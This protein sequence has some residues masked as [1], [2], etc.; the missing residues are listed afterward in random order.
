MN[1]R[2]VVD[3]G[4]TRIA[5]G[6]FVDDKIV[7]LSHHLLSNTEKA[8]EDIST[9]AQ[10]MK[11]DE[12]A[13]CSVVPSVSRALV[14]ELGKRKQSVYEINE[15]SQKVIS[16]TYDS[17][18]ADRIANVAGAYQKY[19]S[20]AANKQAAIVIDC[21][22]ATTLSAVSSSGK[23]M[24][25]LI[26]LGLGNTFRALH[27]ATE[28]LPEIEAATAGKPPLALASDTSNA[29]TSGCI[30]AQVGIIE[31]WLKIAKKE[32]GS[33]TTVIATGGYISII[34]PLTDAF[35]YVD[36]ELTLYGINFIAQAAK[37]RAD[38]V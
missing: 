10:A 2:I 28:Q 26:T 29:I 25:G 1:N 21:G 33:N 31:Q 6:V 24:G 13:I 15:S 36:Q 37:D 11:I 9:D 38:R 12:I 16:N 8:A 7:D 27:Q 34:A 19:L 32:L 5:C 17:L 4:N 20:D 3:I 18:G 30:Y 14:E 22:T 23:F 35:D